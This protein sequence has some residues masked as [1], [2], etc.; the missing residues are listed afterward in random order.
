MSASFP[1]VASGQGRI[2]F[3][4]PAVIF[5][6][7]VQPNIKLNG[8][9]VGASQPG[10]FFF[11]DRAPGD[12]EVLT[13]T[14]VDE[15]LSLTLNEAQERYVKTTIQMGILVGRVIPTLVDPAAGLQELK[16]SSCTGDR[17]L[18]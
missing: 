1:P 6:D 7:G 12:Y 4:R 9:V 2:F 18:K 3:Y 15:K 16:G 8:I 5:G 14:E 10:G 13:S 17:V 11:V